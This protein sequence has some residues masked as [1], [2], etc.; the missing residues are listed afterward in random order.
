MSDATTDPEDTLT[1]KISRE[2]DGA[3]PLWEALIG[4]DFI[5]GIA[6]YGP[7]PLM[8][9]VDLVANIAKFEGIRTDNGTIFLR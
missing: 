3:G 1:I 7:T 5:G 9:M 2:N 8:A 6:G 4:P